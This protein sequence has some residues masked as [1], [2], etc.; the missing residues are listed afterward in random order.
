[1]EIEHRRKFSNILGGWSAELSGELD[2]RK[3]ERNEGSSWHLGYGEEKGSQDQK[4]GYA[5]M[6]G[7]ETWNDQLQQE[8]EH[9]MRKGENQESRCQGPREERVSITDS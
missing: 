5:D 1:M 4:L 7:R 3:E 6:K 9:L 8:K 2:M